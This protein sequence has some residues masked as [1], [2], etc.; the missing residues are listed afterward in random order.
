METEPQESAAPPPPPPPAPPA[1]PAPPDAAGSAEGKPLNVE[2]LLKIPILLS[3][4]IARKMMPLEDILHFSN[5]AVLEFDKP[6]QDPIDLTVGG[7][8]GFT[9]AHGEAVVI[10]DRFGILIRQIGTVR[11]ML[12]RLRGELET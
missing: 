9:I 11:Q 3:A 6:H 5:G 2:E 8:G 12:D 4:V 10:R 7:A 1:P